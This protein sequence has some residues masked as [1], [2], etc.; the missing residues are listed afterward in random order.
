MNIYKM[1]AKATMPKLPLETTLQ[2]MEALKQANLVIA[3]RIATEAMLEAAK[4]SQ[5]DLHF[6]ALQKIYQSMLEAG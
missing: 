1:H 4:E 6:H 2:I 5:P 3:P